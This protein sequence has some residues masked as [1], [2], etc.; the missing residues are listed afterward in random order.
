MGLVAM[1]ILVVLAVV[2]VVGGLVFLGF[3]ALMGAMYEDEPYGQD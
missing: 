3:A 2:I 1:S